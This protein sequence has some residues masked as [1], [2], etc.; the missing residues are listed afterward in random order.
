MH[1]S[2]LSVS[3]IRM[4]LKKLCMR[5]L[6]TRSDPLSTACQAFITSTGRIWAPRMSIPRCNLMCASDRFAKR[7]W[8]D[9]G[10]IDFDRFAASPG[11]I[12]ID[13]VE[14]IVIGNVEMVHK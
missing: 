11:K 2:V 13:A 6:S 1:A 5:V 4:E 3:A 10:R 9:C 8:Q 7:P 12:L 14:R